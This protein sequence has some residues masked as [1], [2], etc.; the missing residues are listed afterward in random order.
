MNA[1]RVEV[2]QDEHVHVAGRRVMWEL[3]GL[4]CKDLASCLYALC[5]EIVRA[6]TWGVYL[7]IGGRRVIVRGVDDGVGI[8]IDGVIVRIGGVV[9][10]IFIFCWLRCPWAMAAACGGY[11]R[12]SQYII[13]G[14]DHLR[15]PRPYIHCN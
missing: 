13:S 1:I 11:L 8:V 6:S 3:A 4:D 14:K 12:I 2:V 5:V 10:Q 9:G 15:P 7:I